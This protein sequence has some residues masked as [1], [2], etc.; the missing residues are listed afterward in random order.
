MTIKKPCIFFWADEGPYIDENGNLTGDS[1]D[2]SPCDYTLDSPYE[3]EDPEQV[4][5]QYY[6]PEMEDYE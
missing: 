2:L 5:E 4:E 3:I 6:L 1:I